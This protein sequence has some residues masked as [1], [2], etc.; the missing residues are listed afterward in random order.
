MLVMITSVIHTSHTSLS[1]GIRSVFSAEERFEQT[2]KTIESVSSYPILFVEGSVLSPEEEQYIKQH[3]TYYVHVSSSD[4]HT[5]SKALGEAT[6]TLYGFQYIL[7]YIPCDY[8]VKISGRYVITKEFV[9]HSTSFMKL[10]HKTSM[11]TG[12][13]KIKY[14]YLNYILYGLERNKHQMIQCKPYEEILYEIVKDL[15]IKKVSIVGL[16]GYVTDGT[17]YLG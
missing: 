11:F 6:L 5:K 2:K 9:N 13:Y 7:N 17:F 12:L 10:I 3:V 15:P 16:C 1:H 14:T 4:V 8:V